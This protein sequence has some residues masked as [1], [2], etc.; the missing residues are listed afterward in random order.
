MD[1]SQ[2]S[3]LACLAEKAMTAG[4]FS[5]LRLSFCVLQDAA[6]FEFDASL[7]VKSDEGPS[8]EVPRLL[9]LPLQYAGRAMGFIEFEVTPACALDDEVGQSECRGLARRC[10][11]FAAREY[12]RDWTQRRLKHGLILVGCSGP[13]HGVELFVEQ[14]VSSTLPV[15]IA[16]EFG[17]EKPTV[18]AAIHCL[19]MNPDGPLIEIHGSN[20]V[21]EPEEWFEQAR[22]GTLFLNAVDEFS[23]ALQNRLAQCLPSRLGQW[24]TVSGPREVRLLASTTVDLRVATAQGRFSRALL[25]ELDFLSIEV[26]PLRE[27]RADVP[28]LIDATLAR[29]MRE[30][31]R[32]SSPQLV[33][34]CERYAWPE[35][36]FELERVI[37]RLAA[38]TS[39]KCIGQ[40]DIEKHSPFLLGVP[41]ITQP[42]CYPAPHDDEARGAS[43]VLNCWVDCTLAGDEPN[44][45]D[46][47]EGL[48]KALSYLSS[49]YTEN[50]TLSRLAQRAHV[51]A[52]HLS[53]LF[54]TVLGT[55]FKELLQRI[56]IERAKQ[57][58]RKRS[59]PRITEVAH[60]VGFADLSHFEKSFRRL[61]GQ[62]PRDYRR[63]LVPMPS[64]AS[65]RAAPLPGQM[66]S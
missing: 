5:R 38:L 45:Q 56:R 52:S 33:S 53:Y 55:S 54:R 18:A 10:A 41:P 40:L 37:A 14:A 39:G 26:P 32:Q 2:R 48:R 13:L 11:L 28:L 65:F 31:S 35:N 22:G 9:R 58:I 24:L 34:A 49:N 61:V 25:A 20:P 36:V 4:G 63:S 23:T 16:G 51:S 57:E 8:S 12:V 29:H 64:H 19:G 30:H 6:T 7:G 50:I 62:C 59:H 3:A 27:R 21:G 44:L 17:T 15:V 42:V 46:L 60:S 47:H 66:G 1:D 43:D